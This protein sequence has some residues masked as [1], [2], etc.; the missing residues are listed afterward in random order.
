MFKQYP[1]SLLL[2]RWKVMIPAILLLLWSTDGVMVAVNE[3]GASVTVR[4]QTVMG[5]VGVQA[6]WIHPT[7]ARSGCRHNGRPNPQ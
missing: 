4:F 7:A 5:V 1:F 3:V 6:G 2:Y